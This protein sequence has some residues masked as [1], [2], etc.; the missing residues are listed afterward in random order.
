MTNG[1]IT[2]AHFSDVHRTTRPLGWS[3]GDGLTRRVTG[4]CNWHWLGRGAR[5]AESDRVCRALVAEFR[6]RQPDVVVFSGD[7]AGIGFEREIEQ[8]AAA[9]GVG[10]P[11]LPLGI[12]VPGNHDYYTH[13]AATGGVFER[14][15]APWQRGERVDVHHY[16]FARQIGDVWLV[17]VCAAIP[18][19]W[20][21][22]A[23]GEVGAAQRHRLR[24]LLRNLAPGPRILVIHY[25]VRLSDSR[26]EKRWH[27]LRDVDE[28]VRVAADGGVCL[29]LHGHRHS[30]YSLSAGTVCPIPL[31]CAGSVSQIGKAGYS[32]LTIAGSHARLHRRDYD[33][34]RGAFGDGITG[35]LRIA[36]R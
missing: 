21:T 16:P 34:S 33:S 30:S 2:I 23:T 36:N 12:A 17:A 22:D 18:H 28:V 15:F 35:Q 4:W 32:E 10:E 6:V 13:T 25:P 1:A 29:W 20:P 14:S 11:G 9:L 7:A 26:P 19:R 3:A 27:R 5:F 24:D 8:T 31:V